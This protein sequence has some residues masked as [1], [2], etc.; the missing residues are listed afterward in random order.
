MQKSYIVIGSWESLL[1]KLSSNSP[2]SP[3]LETQALLQYSQS[4]TLGF[5]G[6][7]EFFC[8]FH[9]KEFC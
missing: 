1:T 4:V 7:M 8:L 9:F 3:S 6:E 5:A 2:I